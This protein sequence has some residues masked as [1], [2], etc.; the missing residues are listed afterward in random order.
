L[1]DDPPWPDPFVQELLELRTGERANIKRA[2]K[3]LDLGRTP[4][5]ITLLQQMVTNY[6]NSATCWLMLGRALVHQQDWPAAEQALKKALELAP[7]NPEIHVQMGVALYYQWNPRA[8][9]HFHKAIE[10]QPDCAAAYYNLALWLVRIHDGAGAT[11]AFRRAIR[12]QPN[13]SD[14]YLGLGSQLARQGRIAAAVVHL[15]HAI[16]LNPADPRG[17]QLLL[18]A[19]RPVA[20]PIFP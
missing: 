4:Q 12:I 10:I 5:A 13:L 16:E 14:A 17:R 6:P 3:L 18:D 7:D 11:E 15:Q 1:R 9:F 2:Q 8:S 19:V 20:I